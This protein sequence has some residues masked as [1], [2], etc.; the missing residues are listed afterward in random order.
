MILMNF[1]STAIFVFFA[2]NIF[3]RVDT[4]TGK[5]LNKTLMKVL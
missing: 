1:I 3:S 5:Y 4:F 2:A